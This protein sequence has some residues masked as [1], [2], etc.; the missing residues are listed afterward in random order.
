[1]TIDW[2]SWMKIET[3]LVVELCV[4][5]STC[6]I[7]TSNVYCFPVFLLNADVFLCPNMYF[8]FHTLKNFTCLRCGSGIFNVES[9][10][11]FQCLEINSKSCFMQLCRVSGGS[12]MYNWEL[13]PPFKWFRIDFGSGNGQTHKYKIE[14]SCI[15]KYGCAASHWILCLRCQTHFRLSQLT[16][17]FLG[18]KIQSSFNLELS[19]MFLKNC[20]LY[21]SNAGPSCTHVTFPSFSTI[22]FMKWRQK[23]I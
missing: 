2:Q 19:K 14:I 15:K 16:F 23:G 21:S 8:P 17:K 7:T 6:F 12:F 1:M 3:Y 13:I 4:N 20:Y 5:S 10:S 22:D 18:S 9:I 11:D